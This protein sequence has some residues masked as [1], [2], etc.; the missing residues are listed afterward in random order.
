[1]RIIILSVRLCAVLPHYLTNGT[2]FEKKNCVEHKM[3]LQLK[4]CIEVYMA[5]RPDG[6]LGTRSGVPW[7]ERQVLC[8]WTMCCFAQSM[9]HHAVGWRVA[10]T[11][12]KFCLGA[13]ANIPKTIISFVISVR[14][15]VRPPAWNNSTP[16]WRIFIKFDSIFRKATEKFQVWVLYM[17][18]LCGYFMRVLYMGTLCG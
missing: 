13:I 12:E 3:C 4:Y 18:T 6:H 15:S 16:T 14:L 2:I 17:G 8:S 9:L 5:N 7:N 10:E 1:M 11:Y